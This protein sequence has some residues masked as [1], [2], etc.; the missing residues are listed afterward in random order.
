MS[1]WR[2]ASAV[3]DEYISAQ[4]DLRKM[5]YKFTKEETLLMNHFRADNF[6]LHFFGSQESINL[7]ANGFRVFYSH[8]LE[9]LLPNATDPSSVKFQLLSGHDTTVALYLALLKAP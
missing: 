5:P 4:F 9:S 3:I 7:A 6:F 8:V 1:G 2:N